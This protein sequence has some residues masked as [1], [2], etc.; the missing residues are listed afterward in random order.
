MDFTSFKFDSSGFRLFNRLDISYTKVELEQW[1][2][3]QVKESEN[4][5]NQEPDRRS[6]DTNSRGS[7]MDVRLR[8]YF[9]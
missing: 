6:T 9:W 4:A 5:L 7:Q 1:N 2:K 8:K 3:N